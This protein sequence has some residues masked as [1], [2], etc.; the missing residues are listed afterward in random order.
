LRDPLALSPAG[1]D[2]AP[3]T[4]CSSGADSA[5]A[6]LRFS[7]GTSSTIAQ[8]QDG[9]N[10]DRQLRRDPQRRSVAA[11]AW[12]VARSRES[13]SDQLADLEPGASIALDQTDKQPLLDVV[14]AWV[15][16]AGEELLSPTGI[17]QLRE[18]LRVDLARTP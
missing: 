11:T 5:S 6:E 2:A 18:G 16:G 17:L 4:A 15:E 7:G 14:E 8:D 9:Q 12:P 3:G 1:R 13:L 10:P